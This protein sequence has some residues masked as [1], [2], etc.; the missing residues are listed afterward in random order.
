MQCVVQGVPLTLRATEAVFKVLTHQG[1]RNPGWKNIHFS[2]S[3]HESP[4][5]K[6]GDQ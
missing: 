2:A 6:I 5:Y 3:G 1:Q 4:E